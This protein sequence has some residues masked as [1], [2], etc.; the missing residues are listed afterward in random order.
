MAP[1]YNKLLEAYR[2]ANAN[3]IQR[4][5]PLSKDD[6]LVDIGGGTAHI[7]LLVHSK[8]GMTNPVVCVDPC[9]EML[10]VAQ[11][12]GAI[13][14][15]ATA[16]EYF[17]S[18]PDSPLKVVLMNGC[19]H[20]FTD[21]EFVFTKLADYM[22]DN[23]VC[24]ATQIGAKGLPIFKAALEVRNDSIEWLCELVQS[25]GLKCQVVSV[26]EPGETDKKLWYNAIRN[27]IFWTCAKFSD[28]ELEQG[29]KELEERFKGQDIIKYNLPF[30]GLII[31]KM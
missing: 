8:F 19:V 25:K 28:E 13:T 24:F 20:H 14:V 11:K 6:Q 27:R 1:Q 23:G 7:S 29:I 4:F 3:F 16:E 21:P 22:P 9:Q 5:I 18:K 17:G 30:E 12:N 2:Q 26:V 31:T 10:D 15:R